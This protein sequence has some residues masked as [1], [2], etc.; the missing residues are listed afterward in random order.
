MLVVMPPGI[1]MYELSWVHRPPPCPCQG[2]AVLIVPAFKLR[3]R[4]ELPP[5]KW[6]PLLAGDWWRNWS[7]RSREPIVPVWLLE[8]PPSLSWSGA[9]SSYRSTF[10][11]PASPQ[12]D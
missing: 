4:R 3:C 11:L 10:T 1:G 8:A 12:S 6:V 2:P 7:S 9:A 5:V